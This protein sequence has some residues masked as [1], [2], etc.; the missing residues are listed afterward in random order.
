[1]TIMNREIYEAMKEAKVSEDRAL[2]AAESVASF[3]TRFLGL[4]KSLTLVKWM[5]GFNLAASLAALYK[6]IA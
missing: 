2:K 5:A 4:D 3:A 1:M 6:L